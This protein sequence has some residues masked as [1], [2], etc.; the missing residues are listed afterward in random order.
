M[1]GLDLRDAKP[2]P[3]GANSVHNKLYPVSESL[4][5]NACS[6][7]QGDSFAARIGGAL[8]AMGGDRDAVQTACQA[9]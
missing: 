5:R 1:T 9:P 2:I 8:E 4:I 7:A 3:D 6:I